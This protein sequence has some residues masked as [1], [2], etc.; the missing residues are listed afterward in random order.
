MNR[1]GFSTG[2]LKLGDFSAALSLMKSTSLSAVELSAL[3]FAELPILVDAIPSLD[4]SQFHYVSIHAPSQFKA[5]EECE[6]VNLLKRVP[7]SWKIVLHPDTIH[8]VS[9]WSC[10]YQQLAIENMDRRKADGRTA[11]EL[12]RWFEKL[13]NARLCFDL[14]HAQ[15][16]DTTMTEAYLILKQFSERL[17]QIHISEL[18]S[19]SHHYPLSY[20]AIRAFSEVAWMVP[21][22]AA[23]IIES[24]VAPEDME[25]E[26]HKARLALTRP[27]SIVQEAALA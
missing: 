16:W 24:R 22:G 15:Q 21:E 7:P 12:A 4:L 11:D 20:G 1:I 8:D 13:P 26:I 25:A 14:A 5:S 2:A 27:T 10:F 6:I 17:C 9:N 18:D 3:R 23:I 19:E